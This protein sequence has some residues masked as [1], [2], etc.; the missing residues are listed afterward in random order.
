MNNINILDC[1]L[2]DGG[3]YNNWCFPRPLVEDYLTA[4]F[5]SGINLVEIGLRTLKKDGF[6]GPYAYSS[7]DHI[8]SLKYPHDLK[9]AVMI[10]ANEFCHLTKDQQET[11]VCSLFSVA[12]E[13][14]ISWVRIAAH[15]DEILTI[16]PTIKKLKSLG[17]NIG[18]NIMQASLHP[19]SKLTEVISQLDKWDEIEVLYFADSLGNMR[20]PD[21]KNIYGIFSSAWSKA[22]GIHAHNNMNNALNNTLLAKE[23]GATWL[24]STITGMGRGAGNTETEYLLI[25]IS[26]NYRDYSPDPIFSLISRHFSKLQE[27]HKWGSNLYYYM[28][29]RREIH[30]TYI[31]QMLTDERYSS[32]EILNVIHSLETKEATSYSKRSL[33]LAINKTFSCKGGDWNPENLEMKTDTV[34]IIAGGKSLF[35]HKEGV[36]NYIQENQPTVI[37]LNI[38]KDFPTEV[39]DYFAACHPTRLSANIHDYS[40]SNKPL[41]A[42]KHALTKESLETLKCGK[43]LDYGLEIEEGKISSQ[44]LYCTLPSPL[45][46]S[47][48]LAFLSQLKPKKI[49]LCGVDGYGNNDPRQVQPNQAINWLKSKNTDIELIAATPTTYD[50]EQQSIYSPLL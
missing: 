27:K 24:D 2:R 1:T 44:Q 40:L 12:S 50:I 11:A 7:D 37:S 45:A 36:L 25:E 41:I 14:T 38:L 35:E 20:E 26:D 23:L 34:M 21:I 48:A 33:D 16:Y 46:L 15:L 43:L 31:Q 32:S 22:I 30:P 9:L 28:A 19:E 49:I 17:Y 42:P 13:S 8:R 39:V 4:A 5:K 18:F 29:A 47:Y 10:N 6:K 3:Y